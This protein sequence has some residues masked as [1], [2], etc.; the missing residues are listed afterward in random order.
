MHFAQKFESGNSILRQEIVF[1]DPIDQLWLFIVW[2]FSGSRAF[3]IGRSYRSSRNIRLRSQVAYRSGN[4]IFTCWKILEFPFVVS[5]LGKGKCSCTSRLYTQTEL[6]PSC[7]TVNFFT[8]R[9]LFGLN[10]MLI[11]RMFKSTRSTVIVQVLK[12]QTCAYLD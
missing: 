11:T 3:N 4:F 8:N 6:I 7:L 2:L 1:P 9:L 10:W 5:F 12:I